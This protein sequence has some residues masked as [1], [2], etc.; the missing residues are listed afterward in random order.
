MG[1][2]RCITYV[3]NGPNQPVPYV[4]ELTC[5]LYSQVRVEN[6]GIE[7][8]IINEVTFK[9]N[10]ASRVMTMRDTEIF[11]Y[12]LGAGQFV[13][14]KV[15]A[16]ARFVASEMIIFEGSFVLPFSMLSF[17]VSVR[18]DFSLIFWS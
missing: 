3:T 11:P 9:N 15:D 13:Q 2:R 10:L 16:V 12:T 18:P 17:Y 6:V 7:T 4:E 14:F 1:N 8:Q 5:I